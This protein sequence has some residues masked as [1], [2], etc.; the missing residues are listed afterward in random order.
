VVV[1]TEDP[2]GLHE[3]AVGLTPGE[4]KRMTVDGARVE[5]MLDVPARPLVSVFLPD[6]LELVKGVPS[7][8]RAHLDQYV[9]ALWPGRAANRRGYAA[10]LAQ[11]NALLTRLRVGEGSRAGLQAWD[12]QVARYALEL[13]ADRRAAVEAT[14]EPFKRIATRLALDGDPRV[15]YRP[16]SRATDPAEFVRE[17]TDRLDSDIDRGFTGHGPHRDELTISRDGREL[18]T[19]GSQGQ[20]RLG[21]LALLLAEREVL[22]AR[23]QEPPLMLLD[24]VMS[25]L[26]AV[27]RA[28]LVDVLQD[29]CGQAVITTTDLDHVPG[30][31]DPGVCRITVAEGGI[32][33]YLLAA[34]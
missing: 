6:R 12:A 32:V 19:Y 17:L 10:A 18:R 21:L 13:M 20:Q 23:R 29:S 2:D 9:A 4:A 14:T 7:L 8:R 33:E 16:R 30:G 15:A 26:D 28:A 31:E 5:R 24:D 25:E 11:R 3:L 34:T 1:T 27:R 22:A